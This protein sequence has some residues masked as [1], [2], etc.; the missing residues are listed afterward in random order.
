MQAKTPISLNP[1]LITCIPELTPDFPRL[2][3]NYRAAHEAPDRR[4]PARQVGA[5]V[6]DPARST[7]S[8]SA[9]D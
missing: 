6:S 5:P 2:Q 9:M 7:C 4:A 8:S 3:S 1:K